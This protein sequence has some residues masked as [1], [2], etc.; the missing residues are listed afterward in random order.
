MQ[1]LKDF[2]QI[3]YPETCIRCYTNL[4][5]NELVLCTSCNYELPLLQISNLEKNQVIDIFYGRLPIKKATSFLAYQKGN[6]TQNLIHNLKYK[7]QEN[8]GTFIGKW[9]GNSLKNTEGFSDVD[10]I[11]PVPLHTTK[12]KKRGYNQVTKFG[13]ALCTELN[14]PFNTTILKRVSTS[15]TQTLKNRLERFLNTETRFKLTDES[16]FENKHILLIDDVITTGATLEACC[17]ELLKTKNITISIATMAFT[18][19]T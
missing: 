9:F 15:K 5:N 14:I 12:L 19:K 1:Y 7:N 3:F 4:L 16:F 6:I 17:N 2:F 10:Y 11:I 13:E 8:I 18:E